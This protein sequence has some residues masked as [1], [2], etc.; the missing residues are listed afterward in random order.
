MKFV[1]IGLVAI[2]A[3]AFA[4]SQ[5]GSSVTD[6]PAPP[7]PPAALAGSPVNLAGLRGKPVVVHFFASWCGPC[8]AEAASFARAP[9]ALHGAAYVVAV[10]WSD[11]R[12]YALAFVHRYGWSFPV[13]SDP[14]GKAGYAYGIQGLPV[15]FVLD[16][17]G[18]IR[19]RLIGPQP[20]A[21]LVRAVEMVRRSAA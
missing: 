20:L 6:R 10:D 1:G 12:S 13:L 17:Q 14:N 3:V 19:R 4:L 9:V 2:L 8:V 18:R 7:L 5:G 15:T 16:A 11:S 21:R